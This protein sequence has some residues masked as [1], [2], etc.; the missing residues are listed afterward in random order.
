LPKLFR[1]LAESLTL[2]ETG[3]VS[4]NRFPAF[5]AA[6]DDRLFTVPAGQ[7]H[8]LR[9]LVTCRAQTLNLTLPPEQ[10]VFLEG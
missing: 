6:H 7:G 2:D 3:K 1:W 10:I 8:Q 4:L 5:V 9:H